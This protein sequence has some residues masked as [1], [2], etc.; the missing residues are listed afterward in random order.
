MPDETVI[1]FYFGNNDLF[2]AIISD[3]YLVAY[4]VRRTSKPADVYSQGKIEPFPVGNQLYARREHGAQKGR[5]HMILMMKYH[6]T[7]RFTSTL[8]SKFGNFN[9]CD[10]KSSRLHTP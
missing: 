2:M 6:T 4:R 1:G 5:T 9:L 3:G 10:L 7:C 8:L